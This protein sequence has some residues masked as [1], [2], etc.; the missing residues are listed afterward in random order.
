MQHDSN[1]SRNNGLDGGETCAKNRS[2]GWDYTT[3]GFV[4]GEEITLVFQT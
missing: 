1:H 4:H 2:C 3:H